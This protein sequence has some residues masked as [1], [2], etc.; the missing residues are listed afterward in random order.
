MG[1]VRE[2]NERLMMHLERIM[3]DYKALQ[4]QFFDIVKQDN[5][6]QQPRFIPMPMIIKNLKN[7][8]S[9]PLASNEFPV[10]LRWERMT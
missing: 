4:M 6:K 1:K 5:R 8:T 2:E 7:R 3:R 9:S 10:L